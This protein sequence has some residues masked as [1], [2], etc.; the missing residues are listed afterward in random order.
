MSYTHKYIAENLLKESKHNIP[1]TYNAQLVITTPLGNSVQFNM[2]LISAEEPLEARYTTSS[3]IN[4]DKVLY[5][6]G[7]LPTSWSYEAFILN[8][9]DTDTDPNKVKDALVKEWLSGVASG[10]IQAF[11]KSKGVDAKVTLS[12]MDRTIEGILGSIQTNLTSEN[13]RLA[14]LKFS[15]LIP[16]PTKIKELF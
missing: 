8:L 1:A 12:Y 6:S 9:G 15:I 14:K 13:S 7:V 2:L 11:Y 16:D 10:E 3:K 4:R 5:L